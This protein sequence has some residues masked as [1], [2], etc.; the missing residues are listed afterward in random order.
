MQIEVGE[1]IAPLLYEHDSLAVPGL[2]TF[3]STYKNAAVDH[4]QRKVQP[5]ALQLQFQSHLQLD[6]GILVN[7]IREKYKVSLQ[8]AQQAVAAYVKVAL[9]IIDK[10]EM[11][12]IPKVGRLYRDYE[13]QL[14]FLEDATNFNTASYGLPVVQFSPIVRAERIPKVGEGQH[15]GGRRMEQSARIAGWFQRYFGWV[16]SLTLIILVA[17]GYLVFFQNNDSAADNEPPAPASRINISPTQTPPVEWP[18]DTLSEEDLDTEAS[19]PD[20][21][22]QYGIILIGRFGNEGNV[23]R[24]V[25]KIFDEGYEPYTEKQGNLTLVGVQ[26]A[27]ER[28]EELKQALAKVRKKFDKRARIIKR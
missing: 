11:V 12:T 7:Y 14:R 24:L 16:L 10:R 20:P 18:T 26:M 8:D 9:E 21:K 15:G 5:P 19:T 4:V 3:V 1:C 13:D 28:E 23:K 25:Q 2:G 6:D 17:G 27:Y 22:Q